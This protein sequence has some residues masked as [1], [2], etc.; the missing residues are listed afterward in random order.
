[1]NEKQKPTVGPR[2]K[3]ASRNTIIWKDLSARLTEQGYTPVM[4]WMSRSKLVL[5]Y[6]ILI[7]LF[8]RAAQRDAHRLDHRVH[9]TT[10]RFLQ[11]MRLRRDLYQPATVE[12][13]RLDDPA[14]DVVCP[15]C[16]KVVPVDA[17]P[18]P[19]GVAA[20]S[21]APIITDTRTDK[22]KAQAAAIMEAGAE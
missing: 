16:G 7:N 21:L 9:E 10:T 20:G 4:I 8:A 13:L 12:A 3:R 11:G 1:M 14:L 19:D 22:D 18:D 2:S 15:H 17:L 6:N 5:A